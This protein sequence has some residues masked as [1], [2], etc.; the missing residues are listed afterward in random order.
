MSP[1]SAE[2]AATPQ[3][4]CAFGFIPIIEIQRYQKFPIFA[5][6]IEPLHGHLEQ[7]K[8]FRRHGE[9]TEQRHETG[10]D[11]APLLVLQG[12]PLPQKRERVTRYAGYC[13]AQIRHSHFHPRL[14]L[15][16]TRSGRHH[17]QKQPGI[18]EKQN[19]TEQTA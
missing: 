5:S 6:P 15:A 14:L 17:A 19:R 11:C 2:E 3:Y 7:E 18:L 10:M 12:L 1:S 8:A 16:R 13:P 9:N 4:Q